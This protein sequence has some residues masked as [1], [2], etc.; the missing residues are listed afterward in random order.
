MDFEFAAMIPLAATGSNTT[1]LTLDATRQ[2][3]HADVTALPLI[4]VHTIPTTELL[5]RR[6]AGERALDERERLA[7]RLLRGSERTLDRYPT[8]PT[9]IFDLFC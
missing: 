5:G 7:T 8:H 3:S 9:Y 1:A 2:S 6:R 4:K